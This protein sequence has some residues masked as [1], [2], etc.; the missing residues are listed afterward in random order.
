MKNIQ[1]FEAWSSKFNRTLQGAYQTA[2]KTNKGFGKASKSVL[3]YAERSI[4][5][6][7]FSLENQSMVKTNFTH[8]PEFI[9]KPIQTF[10]EANGDISEEK[11]YLVLPILVKSSVVNGKES[12]LSKADNGDRYEIIF[13]EGKIFLY[14]RFRSVSWNFKEGDAFL[15]RFSDRKSIEDFFAMTIQAVLSSP[16]P[17]SADARLIYGPIKDF[18]T[19][20]TREKQI[21]LELIQ[22]IVLDK[23][24]RQYTM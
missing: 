5:Q 3:D 24:Q 14:H 12:P 9:L 19:G 17:S 7:V 21:I 4:G 2:Q 13:K 15:V 16:E 1:T 11:K 20:D 6:E 18:V 23:D 22:K 8:D 10:I